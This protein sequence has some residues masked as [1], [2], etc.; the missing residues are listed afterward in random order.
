MG[1]YV[2]LEVVRQ[3]PERVAGLALVS[4]TAR[5][6]TPAQVASR[7]R[8]SML[9]EDG[10]FEALVDAAFTSVV[11]EQHEND[12]ALLETWRRV[13]RAVGAEVFLRQQRA[14]IARADSLALLPTITCPVVVIHG[15]DDRLIP[16][17]MGE[18]IAS[19]IPGAELVTI[20]DAGHFLFAEQPGAVDAAFEGFLDRVHSGN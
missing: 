4:T 14:T 13:T 3:A 15:A 11:A 17:A 18:E 9:V 20:A 16:F 2:A 19:A 1:G 12:A 5:A 6:D 8:Q 7:Q 10:Q